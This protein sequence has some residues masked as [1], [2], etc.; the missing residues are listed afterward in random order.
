M[1]IVIV[2][3]PNY[4]TPLTHTH[5]HT[6]S[7][8]HTHSLTHTHTHTH[9]HMHTHTHTQTHTHT[10]T[11]SHTHTHTH[12]HT[13]SHLACWDNNCSFS[14]LYNSIYKTLISTAVQS[15]SPKTLIQLPRTPIQGDHPPPSQRV[16]H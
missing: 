13:T 3:D 7:L 5:T 8:S 14:S 1:N 11:N 16:F 15:L 4:I 6:L 2:C 10:H 12:T 9:T